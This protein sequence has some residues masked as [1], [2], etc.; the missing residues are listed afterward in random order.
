M[1]QNS[2]SRDD[3][4]ISPKDSRKRQRR[5][6]EAENELVRLV[7]QRHVRQT[8]AVDAQ[9]AALDGN[10]TAVAQAR[11]HLKR[12]LGHPRAKDA[13]RPL[14]LLA[15]Y[16]A[17]CADIKALALPLCP[18]FVA[19]YLHDFARLDPQTADSDNLCDQDNLL[20]H[21]N[22]TPKQRKTLVK[23]FDHIRSLSASFF[24]NIPQ[25]H[26][27]LLHHPVL[28]HLCKPVP[29]FDEERIFR[30]AAKKARRSKKKASHE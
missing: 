23:D 19:L 17:W 5:A 20:D 27:P 11:R 21:Y 10:L 22:I 1:P 14:A 7:Q 6:S 8:Q 25:A 3:L 4:S 15:K 13:R 9:H 2:A 18:E 16:S 30:K 24:P 28:R 26:S 29:G 12:H